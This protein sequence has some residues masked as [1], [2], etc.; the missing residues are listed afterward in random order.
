MNMPSISGTANRLQ[1]SPMRFFEYE[2]DYNLPSTS[3]PTT[4]GPSRKV[5]RFYLR[6]L[7]S[8]CKG[9]SQD[10]VDI[11]QDSMP[12]DPAPAFT[13]GKRRTLDSSECSS[14]ES[15][16]VVQSKRK[17]KMPAESTNPA[18]ENTTM[19][20][21]PIAGNIFPPT[22]DKCRVRINRNLSQ[23]QLILT[24]WTNTKSEITK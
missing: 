6:A 22:Q 11:D 5:P 8:I 13:I 24:K 16:T 18:D 14:E 21:A 4:C 3:G 2:L 1:P 10:P 12:M 17:Q 23:L 7:R 20:Q 15:G 19:D 9:S